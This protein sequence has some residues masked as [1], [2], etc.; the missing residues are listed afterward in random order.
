MTTYE[1]WESTD[2]IVLVEDGHL[3]K[4]A[5]VKGCTLVARFKAKDW[6]EATALARKY[7]RQ[8]KSALEARLAS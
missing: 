5:L 1:I 6:T 4:E 7:E 2:S 3:D 8:G